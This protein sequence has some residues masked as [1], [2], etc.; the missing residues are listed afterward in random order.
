MRHTILLTVDR[1]PTEKDQDFSFDKCLQYQRRVYV[2]AW[3]IRG[4]KTTVG[5]VLGR[6]TS[7]RPM[8]QQ[9]ELNIQAFPTRVDG[10]C[11][12]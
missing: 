11:F 8:Q 6:R 5:D 10:G 3:E 1:S 4:A 2:D 9:P 7:D 12:T